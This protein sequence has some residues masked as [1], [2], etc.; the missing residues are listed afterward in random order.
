MLIEWASKDVQ[1]LWEDRKHREKVLSKVNAKKFERII[2]R[3]RS[4][5]SVNELR[6]QPIHKFEQPRGNRSGQFSMRMTRSDRIIFE[7]GDQPDTIRILQVGGH[8]G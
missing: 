3:L 4:V 7:Q 8:Y 6:Q 5:N 2:L 1:R